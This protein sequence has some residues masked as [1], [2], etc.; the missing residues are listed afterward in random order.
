M[1]RGQLVMYRKN[2]ENVPRPAVPEGYTIRTY[3]DGDE[4]RLEPVFQECF[5]PGWSRDRVVKTFIEQTFWSPARMCVLCHGETVIGTATA[6]EDREHP[7][8]GLVHYVAVRS[9][10]KGHRLGFALTA[11]ALEILKSMGYDDVWLTT[12]DFRLPAIKTYLD[13]GFEP[14]C[15]DPSHK[16]R[17]EIVMHKMKLRKRK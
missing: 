15:K 8:H 7:G 3:V 5:D 2:I 17:W 4:E 12:D 6:W 13:L 1:E 16:E 10:H 11:R 14:V 9:E